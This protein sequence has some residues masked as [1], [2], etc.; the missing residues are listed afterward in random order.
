MKNSKTASGK[1]DE[2]EEMSVQMSNL[3]NKKDYRNSLKFI[4]L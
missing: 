3:F 1:E 4:E 2:N